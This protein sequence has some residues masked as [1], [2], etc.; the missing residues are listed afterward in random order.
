MS[1]TSYLYL[2]IHK[3]YIRCLS[4]FLCYSCATYHCSISIKNEV[5]LMNKVALRG[6]LSFFLIVL[7]GIYLLSLIV[8]GDGLRTS[9]PV[10]GAEIAVVTG[11]DGRVSYILFESTINVLIESICCF[12]MSYSFHFSR[13][14]FISLLSYVVQVA[15]RQ[16]PFHTM[17]R[18][19]L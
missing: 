16:I 6:R 8:H 7:V 10:R 5:C 4:S 15:R 1:N 2:V 14:V 3:L 12:T 11:R 13:V 19:L 17:P 18:V 9:N